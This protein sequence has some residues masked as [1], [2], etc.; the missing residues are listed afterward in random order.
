[1]TGNKEPEKTTDKSD[2]TATESS[3][4]NADLK[5][6]VQAAK[7]SADGRWLDKSG[8]TIKDSFVITLK[9]NAVYVDK[10]G[11]MKHGIGFT[12]NG[13]RY[14]ASKSGAIVKNGF[15]ETERGNTVYATKNG[16]LKANTVFK[17]DGKQYVAKKSGALV[18]N[19]WHT[20][21][22]KKYYCDKNGMVK[23]IKE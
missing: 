18:K 17:V 14:Y 21:G 19:K 23:D 11:V 1:M 8:K 9:G 10:K 20:I 5:N 3:E 2:E 16:E 12:V 7:K 6:A 13:K 15:F 4:G 22:K